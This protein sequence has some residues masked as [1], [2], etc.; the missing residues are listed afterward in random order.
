MVIVIPS[1][2]SKNSHYLPVA[3][4]PPRSII[5]NAA[6]ALYDATLWNMALIASRMRFIWIATVCGKLKADF[7]Y[8]NT[9]GWNTFPLP[10]LSE[11]NK[12]KLT[13]CADDI[14]WRAKRISPSPSPILMTWTL[15][16]KTCA[17]PMIAMMKCWSVSILIG[18]GFKN[19]TKR[20]EKLFEFYT[21]MDLEQKKPPS[22]RKASSWVALQMLISDF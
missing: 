21:K 4:L 19:D 2:R 9:I 16:P 10:P 11:A 17:S 22:I 7:P 1:V 18:G 15:C 5:S 14:F 12:D 8:S 20:L 3:P 13:Q 6:F